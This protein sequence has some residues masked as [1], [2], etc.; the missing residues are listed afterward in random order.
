MDINKLLSSLTLEEKLGQLSQYALPF[1]D[2]T[3]DSPL[4]GPDSELKLTEGQFN[5]IGSTYSFAG[6]SVM[7]DAQKKHLDNDPKKIPM[8]FMENVVHGYRTIYPVPLA[9]GATFDT[10]LMEK[11]CAMAAKEAAAGGV[12]VTFAPMVDLTRDPRWGRCVESTGEDP[13]LN[14]E[15][16][17]AQVRGYQGEM[18]PSKNIAACVKHYAAYG[19]AEAGRDYNT[20]DMSE[21]TLRD[22]YLPSYKAAVDEDVRMVMTSFNLLNGIPASGNKWLVKDVL[23]DEWGFEGVVISDYKAFEEMCTHGYCATEAECAEKAISAT[24]D[25]EMMSSCY[26]KS[27]SDLIA[28]GKLSLEQI[29]EAV[30]RVLK[31]KDEFGLFENPYSYAS[32]EESEKICLCDE[33]RALAKIAAEKSAVLLKNNGVLPFDK[34]KTKSV[35]VV[36]PLA[37][38]NEL[39]GWAC[40]GKNEETVTVLQGIRNLLPECEV[41]FA[42]GCSNEINETDCSEI[43]DAVNL[44]RACD[45]VVL[46]VGER[47]DMSGEGK[48]RMELRLSWAQK[49]LIKE[50]A[51]AN[52]N[53]A[54]VLHSGRPLVLADCIE[55]MSALMT[56]WL[57]STEGGNAVAQLLFGDK[58]FSG[59]LP[60]TFPRSE[61]QLPISYNAYRTGRPLLNDD[62]ARG[63]SSCYFDMPNTPL[64]PF[65]YGLSYTDFE[66]S[67]P[68][69][70]KTQMKRGESLEVCVNVK[71][72]GRRTGETVLQLYICDEYA[73]LVRPVK[74][75]KGFKKIELSPNEERTVSFEITE[76]MLKFWSANG[77]FEAE[78]GSFKVWISDSSITGENKKFTLS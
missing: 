5:S 26:F 36:G 62:W 14:S 47:A 77:K 34:E 76:D 18:D 35:A 32:E 46:C 21:R 6:A 58:N 1:M 33:H 28:Q 54:V 69:L 27:V 39:D 25:I 15:M 7:K 8:L 30:L 74:E 11:C 22:F 38:C 60:M 65:G 50:V 68:I 49:M 75:L 73:S 31:L 53:T 63:F 67:A 42:R 45:A 3:I 41:M 48:S 43:Q 13:Y 12:H 78:D 24:N 16:A 57:P 59:K 29:D 51:K 9:M 2:R 23:R 20:T 19:Q 56:T 4:T 37:D 17:R 10:Q 61:G 66:I 64:F 44:A 71:N 72:V 70:K 40:Q 55:D 52:P